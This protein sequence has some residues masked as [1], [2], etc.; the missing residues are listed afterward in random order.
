M[1]QFF[2]AL[3]WWVRV[4]VLVVVG[5]YALTLLWNNST[6]RAWIWYWPGKPAEE[7]S[8]VALIIAAFVCGGLIFTIG[9][10]LGTAMVNLRRTR[11]AR[12]KRA[13]ELARE[14]IERKA[15]MLRVKPAPA[16]IVR[17]RPEPAKPQPEP[18]SKPHPDV[19]PQ[20]E[21]KIQPEAK[22]ETKVQPESPIKPK[23]E[24]KP[25]PRPEPVVVEP[26]PEATTAPAP[27][28]V[29]RQERQAEK[30]FAD[31]PIVDKQP[32][33]DAKVVES[34]VIERPI[35]EVPSAAKPSTPAVAATQHGVLITPPPADEKPKTPSQP[36]NNSDSNSSTVRSPNVAAGNA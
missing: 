23:P 11:A 30:P 21:V 15:S 22:P 33:V 36:E 16:P 32:S 17:P 10:A 13:A 24:P 29:I 27:I 31:K 12:R 7:T 14:E 3:W 20:P 25:E 8:V 34:R 6:Q 5:L 28:V 35:A 26:L 9:W 4:I 1:R 2:S 19:K 18:E